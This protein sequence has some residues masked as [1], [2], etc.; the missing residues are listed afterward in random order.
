MSLSNMITAMDLSDLVTLRE[1]MNDLMGKQRRRILQARAREKGLIGLKMPLYK[2]RGRS[3]KLIRT[4][5]VNATIIDYDRGSLE[6]E[7]IQ[8]TEFA[9]RKIEVSEELVHEPFQI[10]EET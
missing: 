4:V 9:T 7:V 6:V 3:R 8:P 10:V 2:G 5:R 1:A